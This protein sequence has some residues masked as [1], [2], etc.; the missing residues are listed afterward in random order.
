MK[1]GHKGNL[2]HKGTHH[3]EKYKEKKIPTRVQLQKKEDFVKPNINN[4][5]QSNSEICDY[6]LMNIK[7]IKNSR[8]GKISFEHPNYKGQEKFFE[9][10]WYPSYP[11]SVYVDDMILCA[12]IKIMSEHVHFHFVC[13]YNP[14]FE[15][16]GAEESFCRY[17]RH[18]IVRKEQVNFCSK[19]GHTYYFVKTTPGDWD[20]FYHF[21]ENESKH[22][23]DKYKNPWDAYQWYVDW[24]L[25]VNKK[26]LA[27]YNRT[28]SIV[29]RTAG[30]R[31]VAD[32]LK[33][34]NIRY[35]SEYVIENLVGDNHSY[36]VADFYLP[37]ED[38]YIEVNGGVN[39]T[40]IENREKELIRYAE[41][42]EVYEKNKMRFIY[43][44]PSD[45]AH[46]EYILALAIADLIKSG[47]ISDKTLKLQNVDSKTT[48]SDILLRYKRDNED[49]KLKID[50]F[51][52]KL[53]RME[54][55]SLLYKMSKPFKELK[56][57][58]SEKLLGNKKETVS[59]SKQNTET[60]LISLIDEREE[61]EQKL[62]EIEKQ[63]DK[64]ENTPTSNIKKVFDETFKR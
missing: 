19:N 5:K 49:L 55:N 39:T 50:N 36:R 53:A 54:E 20:K 28:D 45:L 60:K 2:K 8:Y 59:K 18:L 26:K 11:Y 6:T 21:G 32:F 16:P 57:S 62:K 41:K 58:I 63:L 38:I 1:R 24:L 48:E 30:E 51:Y 34:L 22:F 23:W 42:K 56:K 52:N 35:I 61:L 47:K 44:F 40:N 14:K 12:N 37:K 29:E 9:R 43:V 31:I 46:G 25:D 3:Y 15:Y 33:R 4:I 17:K 27:K 7:T 64:V 10:D 13:G